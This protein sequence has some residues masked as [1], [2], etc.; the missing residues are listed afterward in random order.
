MSENRKGLFWISFGPAKAF[1]VIGSFRPWRTAKAIYGL[2]QP[3][4]WIVFA[5]TK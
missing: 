1:P 4:D 2:A 3:S 5:R